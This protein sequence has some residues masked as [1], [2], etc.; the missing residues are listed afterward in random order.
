MRHRIV[1]LLSAGLTRV[2]TV[3]IKTV[4]SV[5]FFGTCIAAIC[6]YLGLPIPFSRLFHDV[7]AI[8]RLANILS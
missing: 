2:L 4:V 3:A 5:V 8:T 6:H 7:E 1:Q